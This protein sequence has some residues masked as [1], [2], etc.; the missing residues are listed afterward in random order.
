ML[1]R[2]YH[3]R[4]RQKVLWL[5]IAVFLFFLFNCLPLR[6]QTVNSYR[7]DRPTPR[8][9]VADKPRFLYRSGFRKNPN[10]EYEARVEKSLREIE[11]RILLAENGDIKAS[12]TIW[13]I[14]L[15][16]GSAERGPDSIAFEM[17]NEGWEYKVRI[18]YISVSGL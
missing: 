6:R 8:Y 1:P 18:I 9:D 2:Q 17:E 16:K 10:H 5:L 7:I 13:Q 14:V 4:C 3:R 15:V 12:E 11:E